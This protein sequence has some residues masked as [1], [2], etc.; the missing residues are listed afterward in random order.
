MTSH[1]KKQL[2]A[3]KGQLTPQICH[4]HGLKLFDEGCFKKLKLLGK[5]AFGEVWMCLKVE[6]RDYVAVKYINVDSNNKN[7]DLE[8]LASFMVEKEI[9]E[10]IAQKNTSSIAKFLGA[11]YLME[12]TLK[13]IKHVILVSESGDYSL[14]Q[15][16]KER[17]AKK[18]PYQPQEVLA[19][20]SQ[21]SEGYAIL[22]ELRIYHSDTKLPNL[23]FSSKNAKFFLI[24]FGVSKLV[25]R[26]SD[27][28]S[29]EEYAG[30]GTRGWFSPE[31]AFYWELAKKGLDLPEDKNTF[32]P[33]KDDIWALGICLEKMLNANADTY[34]GN[35][36]LERILKALKDKNSHSRFNGDQLH[37]LLKDNNV[38]SP[39]QGANIFQT[40]LEI[41]QDL[42]QKRRKEDGFQAVFRKFQDAFLPHEMLEVALEERK[43]LVQSFGEPSLENGIHFEGALKRLGSINI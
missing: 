19:F 10:R 28:V 11:F 26:G 24:D 12:G 29:L 21:I 43:G 42:D 32:N 4:E 25:A 30:G 33:F 40:D 8:N 36:L 22:Q 14:D 18:K 15:L 2:E 38:V 23:V 16:I 9:L 34:K 39:S 27:D 31:K 7:K 5:G 6:N 17:D 3:H 1:I 13:N 20:L 37:R 41:A 35:D